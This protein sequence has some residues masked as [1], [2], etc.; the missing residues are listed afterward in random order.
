MRTS[1]LCANTSASHLS[2]SFVGNLATA[3][4]TAPCSLKLSKKFALEPL[5]QNSGQLVDVL[6]RRVANESSRKNRRATV[7]CLEPLPAKTNLILLRRPSRGTRYP[8]VKTVETL[9]F[10]QRSIPSP[11]ISVHSTLTLTSKLA[12]QL[13]PLQ[14]R[15][16][17]PTKVK[18]V[19]P[20]WAFWPKSK[21]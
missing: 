5:A 8:T 9:C 6:K 17:S 18:L 20:H 13:I 21:R 2:V 16:E 7:T 15:M 1:G 11:R 14:K 3:R 12:V 4:N 19:L 10:T